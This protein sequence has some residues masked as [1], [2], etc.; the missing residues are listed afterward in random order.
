MKVFLLTCLISLSGFGVVA[1]IQQEPQSQPTTDVESLDGI[2][3]ALYDT[4]SGPAGQKRDWDRFRGLFHKEHAM[5]TPLQHS[6]NGM[7]RPQVFT[8][9]EFIANSAPYM[10]TQGFYEQEI[11]REVH[12]FGG[13][14]QV[15]S[16]YA[17]RNKLED[18]KPFMRGINSIQLFSNGKRWF[19]HSILWA[20][21]DVRT[22]REIPAKFL[23]KE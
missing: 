19:I 5:L 12:Q 6:P 20:S 4:I 2:L 9:E 17:G 7:I 22:K 11:H 15:F 14:A 10:E 21:E 18:E 23:P 1:T 3:A 8:V 13:V 16:T